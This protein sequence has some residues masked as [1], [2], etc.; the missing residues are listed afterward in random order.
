MEKD[1]DTVE[2][3]L[4]PEWWKDKM[5]TVEGFIVIP[6]TEYDSDV[7]GINYGDG[8][9]I[10]TDFRTGVIVKEG[11]GDRAVRFHNESNVGRW[12][13]YREHGPIRFHPFRE[14]FSNGKK[15]PI[16]GKIALR[17]RLEDMILITDK[18]IFDA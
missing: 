13:H 3:E 17:V 12:C 10:D 6:D 18:V 2:V 5:I 7:K 14:R 16:E 1:Y 15:Y 8:V 4:T 11:F 9:G